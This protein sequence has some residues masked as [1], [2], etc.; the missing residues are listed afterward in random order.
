MKFTRKS[1][2]PEMWL[3]NVGEGFMWGDKKYLRVGLSLSMVDAT[4]LGQFVALREDG[5]VVFCAGDSKEYIKQPIT[6][7]SD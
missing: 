5:L 6:I 3:P 4:P 7:E 2:E 1:T